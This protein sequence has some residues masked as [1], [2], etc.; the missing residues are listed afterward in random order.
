[1]EPSTALSIENVSGPALQPHIPDL[2]RLRIT[3][4]RDFPY[5]YDGSE[6]YES[7]YLRTYSA[8]PLALVIL[9]RDQM[10]GAIVGASTGIPM[11][12]ET[13]ACQRPFKAYG[14]DP[15]RVF[16]GG[17]S[18]LLKKY[19]GRRIYRHFM[20]RRE[21]YAIEHGFEY[22]CFCGVVRP[23]D[24]PLRPVG[25]Q[26]LDQVWRHFGFHPEPALTMH[27]SWKDIDQDQA[28]NHLMQF[29]IKRFAL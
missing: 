19:R 22:L 3:V 24:H 6:S 15:E 26:S 4:F 23:S 18:V 7:E 13:E 12:A 29:W 21:A 25:Y 10:T 16:Y 17:E 8:S 27:M 11:S 28:T 9:V 20:E 2:A 1:M 14:I 5:L